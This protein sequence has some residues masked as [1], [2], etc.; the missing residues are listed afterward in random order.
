MS[1]VKFSTT[2]ELLR[3]DT[4]EAERLM[5]L[6]A[7]HD[8][9]ERQISR[10]REE[11]R[12]LNQI[13]SDQ[14]EIISILGASLDP[15][16]D[17]IGE[18]MPTIE[19]KESELEITKS[20]SARGLLDKN[21]NKSKIQSMDSASNLS[22]E[23][24]S[25][26]N[27]QPMREGSN[28]NINQHQSHSFIQ[29]RQNFFTVPQVNNLMSELEE[30]TDYPAFFRQYPI[31][32]LLLTGFYEN[33]FSVETLL[34]IVE[35]MTAQKRT[36]FFVAFF[37][38]VRKSGKFLDFVYSLLKVNSA[39]GITEAVENSLPG[40]SNCKRCCYMRYDSQNEE[41]VF[42]KEKIKLRFPVKQ[43]IFQRTLQ[44]QSPVESN[45]ED[46]DVSPSDRVI[47]QNNRTVMIIPVLSVRSQFHVLGLIV[48]FD[49]FGG[50]HPCDYLTGS[51]VARCIA[52]ITPQIQTLELQSMRCTAY[53]SAVQTYVN[54]CTSSD[55]ASLVSNISMSFCQYFS[56]EAV[57]IFKVSRKQQ[58]YREI[59]RFETLENTFPISSGI[60]GS[61]I[62]NSTTINLTKPQFSE[63]YNTEVDCYDSN[64]FSS[65]LLVGVITD[66]KNIT[67][68]AIALYNKKERSSFTP[69]DEESLTTICHHLLPLL[70][71]S[72]REKKLKQT[73]NR[74]KKQLT[75]AEALTDVIASLK[76]PTDLESM[77]VRMN[78]F[79]KEN[80]QFSQITL[81]I[82][83]TFRK[84][85]INAEPATMEVIPLESDNP[86]AECARTG[87]I[88]ERNSPLDG[89]RMLFC[90]VI[91]SSS[92]V[93]GVFKLGGA[94]NKPAAETKP[95]SD[96]N[97]N[98]G[99]NKGSISLNVLNTFRSSLSSSRLLNFS[100]Q[101]I[102][103]EKEKD[104]PI[105][106]E[107]LLQMTKM[108]QKVAGSVLEGAAKHKKFNKKKQ[109][110][111][112][113]SVALYENQFESSFKV[114]QEVQ[115]LVDSFEDIDDQNVNIESPL[116]KDLVFANTSELSEKTVQLIK[117]LQS[118][119]SIDQSIFASPKTKHK[120]ED[121]TVIEDESKTCPFLSTTAVNLTSM[122]EGSVIQNI[123]E[124]FTELSFLQFFGISEQDARN[125]I[126]E[127]RE[128]HPS[129]SFR[130]WRLAVD[131]FQFAAF[132]M[133]NTKF[134]QVLSDIE[135]ISVLLYLL[136]LYSDPCAMIDDATPEKRTKYTL[137][138]S[139]L[140]STCSALFAACAWCEVHIL[141]NLQPEE[142]M[143]IW[144]T[145]DE[146][147]MSSSP[148][149]FINTSPAVLLCCLA[150]FSYVIRE[151]NVSVAWAA[152]KTKEDTDPDF[153][154][155]MIEMRNYQ[156]E[157]DRDTQL[158]PMMEEAMKV[159]N[160]IVTLL[161]RVK[162]N[163][164]AIIDSK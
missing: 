82:I 122:D 83:D 11:E 81:Y 41:L 17:T 105:D 30:S 157:F 139:G 65:S 46:P 61:C 141:D 70:K 92:S 106:N 125:F 42:M 85:L 117:T 101:E 19:E 119:N 60:V 97:M 108:W 127:L 88:I 20:T 98:K 5:E 114:W 162:A 128:I 71:N 96:S 67:K 147:E 150:R 111:D 86:A 40:F 159:D 107:T 138:T 66:T 54:L 99:S 91:N 68:W 151:T 47:L 163:Y 78:K 113:M 144:N 31:P 135:M 10:L 55:L 44:T 90:A 50:F 51:I 39:Y 35:G 154:D 64:S 56:C 131:H 120:N 72:W 116:I 76:S 2:S 143:N 43:G 104:D 160:Q 33:A 95:N 146:L 112:H 38:D 14:K 94:E 59:T 136:T 28:L 152:L 137:E 118:L 62:S 74:S 21:Y 45:F 7:L 22:D 77:L 52:E 102:G 115:Y 73:I 87:R 13:I 24:H 58:V 80:T 75:Q 110:I 1:R 53:Q 126:M 36:S 89:T 79:F 84:E 15:N 103:R 100:V 18:N 142:K 57:K 37:S 26:M 132:L 12:E 161:A 32:M 48:L 3:E 109:L 69:L 130:S 158:I 156:M 23:L 25:A 93:I 16:S 155:D 149:A 34:N 4:F 63:N 49:K 6:Y 124:A 145:I 148:E 140:F 153:A 29:S 133:L 164:E 27:T 129:N 8:Y 134:G 123:V 121:L 9:K